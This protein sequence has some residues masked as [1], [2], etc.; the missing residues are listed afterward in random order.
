VKGLAR[1]NDL[2]ISKFKDLKK[3]AG[4]FLHRRLFVA[5]SF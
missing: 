2:K 5:L 4:A 3:T 1:R